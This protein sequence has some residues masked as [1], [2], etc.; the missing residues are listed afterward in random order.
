MNESERTAVIYESRWMILSAVK[1]NVTVYNLS[2][3][4]VCIDS[5]PANKLSYLLSNL[6]LLSFYDSLQDFLLLFGNQ[7]KFRVR[8]FEI[9]FATHKRGSFVVFDITLI[10][11]FRQLD[12]HGE[13]LLFK[14]SYSKFIGVS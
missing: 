13:A 10:G 11:G 3:I 14:I 7:G 1:L 5:A 8:D 6:R 4:V 12:I 2:I 9:E